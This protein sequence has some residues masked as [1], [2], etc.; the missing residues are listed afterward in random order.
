MLKTLEEL[1]TKADKER[2]D[3]ARL[4]NKHSAATALLVAWQE[5]E[6]VAFVLRKSHDIYACEVKKD[7]ATAARGAARKWRYVFPI[8]ARKAAI[9]AGMA[10]VL[11]TYEH[12]LSLRTQYH[13]NCGEAV[14]AAI[15]EKLGRVYKKDSRPFY[16]SG[17][18]S[19]PSGD[20]VQVKWADGGHLCSQSALEQLES[21]ALK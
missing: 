14:E 10:K 19:L 4:Y 16:R 1:S 8:T 12:F 15:L 21:G 18:I 11:C 9:A 17:D 7:K 5:G 3:C 6:N 20:E 13:C 2:C